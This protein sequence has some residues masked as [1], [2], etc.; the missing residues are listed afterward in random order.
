MTTLCV[1]MTPFQRYFDVIVQALT[2]GP[3][4]LISSF[5][6]TNFQKIVIKCKEEREGAKDK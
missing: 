3:I 6:I 5:Y 4:R 2:L 1:G